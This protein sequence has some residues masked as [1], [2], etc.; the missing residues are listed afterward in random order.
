MLSLLVL[1][2]EDALQLAYKEHYMSTQEQ[3]AA[4]NCDNTYRSNCIVPAQN[5]EVSVV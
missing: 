4:K 2:L 5:M 3:R 1:K